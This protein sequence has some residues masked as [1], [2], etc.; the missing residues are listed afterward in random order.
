MP[1]KP[2]ARLTTPVLLVKAHQVN[3]DLPHIGLESSAR[4]IPL[5]KRLEFFIRGVLIL[6]PTRAVS[7]RASH[8][9]FLQSKCTAHSSH[10]SVY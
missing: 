7:I 3:H 2:S 6:I 9:K 1:L 10:R 8:L 5:R 4:N